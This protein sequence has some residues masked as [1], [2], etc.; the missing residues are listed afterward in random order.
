MEVSFTQLKKV[1]SKKSP[2]LQKQAGLYALAG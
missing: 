2:T 1:L